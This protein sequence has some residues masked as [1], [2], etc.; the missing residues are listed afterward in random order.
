MSHDTASSCQPEE[1]LIATIAELLRGSRSIAVGVS[2]PIPGS[3]ALLTR[4]L[5][6]EPVRVELLESL[7]G[8]SL[9]RGSVELFDRAARGRIDAFFLGGGQIDGQ[10]NINL[11]GAGDYPASSVRWPGS[12]GS[13]YLYFLVPKVILFREEHSRRVLVP[14][15]DFV[16]APGVSAPEVYRRGG[17]H[18]LVTSMAVF[19]FLPEPARFRLLSVHAGHTLEEVLEN[20]GFEFDYEANP[21]T[22]PPPSAETLA[23]IRGP[24]ADEIAEAYPQFA[25]RVFGRSS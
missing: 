8:N 22:T 9:T 24:V 25:A 7:R 18:S 1:L 14:R 6:A 2:S 15:V 16:S 5:S 10:G 12:F 3:A 23:T 21:E 4:A 13:A 17:P 20:T 19:R 11:V